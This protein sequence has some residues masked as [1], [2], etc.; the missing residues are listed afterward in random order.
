MSFDSRTRR[1]RP[2]RGISLLLIIQKAVPPLLP[3]CE[4]TNQV[5][6]VRNSPTHCLVVFDVTVIRLARL[7]GVLKGV[8]SAAAQVGHVGPTVG[9][10]TVG[11]SEGSRSGE[12]ATIVRQTD[13]PRGDWRAACKG[14]RLGRPVRRGRD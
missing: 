3:A 12:G 2:A 6:V 5:G 8:K 14:W 13:S 7:N 9:V 1:F 11:G 10:A 4:G